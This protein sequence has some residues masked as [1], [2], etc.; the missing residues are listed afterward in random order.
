VSTAAVGHDLQISYDTRIVT[1]SGLVVPVGDL[2]DQTPSA[3]HRVPIDSSSGT[4]T[5]PGAGADASHTVHV[6][7]AT[8]DGSGSPATPTHA[9]A[10]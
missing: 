1:P 4:V 3:I 7:V 5:L 8:T 10:G 9:R 6:S 2:H